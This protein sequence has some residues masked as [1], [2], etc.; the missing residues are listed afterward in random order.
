[1]KNMRDSG[2]NPDLGA[3]CY[4][5]WVVMVIFTPFSIYLPKPNIDKHN[6]IKNQKKN[7]DVGSFFYLSASLEDWNISLF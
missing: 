7:P 5:W 1:M 4:S 2:A 6:S 3:V